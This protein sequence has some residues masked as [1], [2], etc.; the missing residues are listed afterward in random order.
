MDHPKNL[1]FMPA[2]RI[3]RKVK[4]TV[5]RIE[6]VCAQETDA[7]SLRERILDVLKRDLRID[8]Y[9][10]VMTDPDSEV[11]VDPLAEVP[12]LPELP[13]LVRL[14]Y[15]TD[16]NRWTSLTAAAGLREATG[17]QPD[18]SLVYRELLRRYDVG[19]VASTVFRDRFG[20][21]G[22]LD[23]WRTGADARFSGAELDLLTRITEPVTPALRRAQART[24]LERP[25]QRP[26]TGPVVLL[27]SPQLD[28]QGQTPQTLEYLRTLLPPVPD[29]PPIP[30]AAYNVAAQLLAV[31]A[32]VDTHPP[33][34]RV[35]LTE[36]R[37]LT[38]RA[39]RLAVD[40]AVTI[41]TATPSERSDLFA[42]AFGLSPRE[43]ELLA[44][45]AAGRDTKETA[46]LMFVSEYT[47]QDHLK[48]I[49]AKSGVR[50]RRAL[51]GLVTGS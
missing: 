14:K 18:R 42:R 29:A 13:T 1:G 40:I 38:V 19:D 23:L 48:A 39:D 49:S 46:A 43:S 26:P 7:R 2:R 31:E 3:L 41:E 22:F 45:L 17:D 30:A 50:T 20:C 9:A 35:H 32:G 36:G 25:T 24:L 12:C 15:L 16:V 27:L 47:I 34:A 51:V 44:H 33:V 4:D 11:G 21:W 37:W 6:R 28:V 10:F 8:A 5:A